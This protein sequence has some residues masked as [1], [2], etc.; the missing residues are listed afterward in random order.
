[1]FPSIINISFEFENKAKF[2]Y[3]IH[4]NN[5]FYLTKKV[6]TFFVKGFTILII[7]LL[8]IL[9]GNGSALIILSWL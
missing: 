7:L 8:V 9:I 2:D 3:K 1:M 4:G 6:K 5:S